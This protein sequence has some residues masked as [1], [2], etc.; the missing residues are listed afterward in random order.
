MQLAL[1]DFNESIKLNNN[2]LE[3]YLERGNIHKKLGDN[4]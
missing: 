4:N 2:Y 3:A 1:S